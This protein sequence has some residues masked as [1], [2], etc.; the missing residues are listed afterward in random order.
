MIIYPTCIVTTTSL[1]CCQVNCLIPLI[2]G[3]E[4]FSRFINLLI[5]YLVDEIKAPRISWS[6]VHLKLVILM[7]KEALKFGT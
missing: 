7:L 6:Q 5:H 4:F 2:H 3:L 1:G